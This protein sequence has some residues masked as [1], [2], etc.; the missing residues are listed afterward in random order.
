MEK[1]L[2]E[3]S[4]QRRDEVEK[5]EMVEYCGSGCH[6][7][8]LNAIQRNREE[9]SYFACCERLNLISLENG[10]NSMALATAMRTVF[11]TKICMSKANT[12]HYYYLFI[13]Y[14]EVISTHRIHV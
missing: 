13:F 11:E 14:L 12:L 3:I 2:H 4:F 6:R 7:L 8:M 9:F 10:C 5:K 1:N